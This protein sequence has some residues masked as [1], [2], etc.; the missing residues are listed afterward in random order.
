MELRR[1]CSPTHHGLQPQLPCPA[2]L[3]AHAATPCPMYLRCWLKD[4]RDPAAPSVNMRGA[5]TAN[6]NPNPDPN[7]SPNLDPNPNSN[8]ARTRASTARAG[9]T[10][11]RRRACTGSAAPSGSRWGGPGPMARGVAGQSG[12]S[13]PSS[14]ASPAVCPFVKVLIFK[15]YK[16]GELHKNRWPTTHETDSTCHC[17][18]WLYFTHYSRRTGGGGGLVAPRWSLLWTLYDRY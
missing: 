5:Y 9:D 6:P 2:A 1:R 8:Q 15:M 12:D 11:T 7:P 3:C 18:S 10:T 16:V 4:Q 13:W 14:R 17:A